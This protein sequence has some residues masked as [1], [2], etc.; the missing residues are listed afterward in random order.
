MSKEKE[1]SMKNA[2]Y[3]Q[4]IMAMACLIIL[5]C[6]L[7]HRMAGD[8][9]NSQG[10]V[11]ALPEYA[12]PIVDTEK[13]KATNRLKMSG[14]LLED[15]IYDED[16]RGCEFTINIYNLSY[17]QAVWVIVFRHEVDIWQNLDKQNWELFAK[18]EPVKS[19]DWMGY[20][21]YSTDPDAVGPTYLRIGKIVGIYDIPECL[22]LR[23][24]E[25]VLEAFAR[26]VPQTC[27]GYS[28]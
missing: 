10:I 19:E 1:I 14:Y 24:D 17:T 11:S 15:K 22:K 18:I 13:C 27:I 23:T 3:E 6:T 9:G 12:D 25:R 7:I 26:E 28:E 5:A 8:V 2:R 4:I 16:T 20:H 21:S